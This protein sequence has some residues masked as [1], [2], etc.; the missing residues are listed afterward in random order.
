MKKVPLFTINHDAI[1]S[2]EEAAKIALVNDILGYGLV[3]NPERT[4]DNLGF[5]FPTDKGFLDLKRNKFIPCA[6]EGV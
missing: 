3:R 4:I 6:K 1:K 2:P 5:I